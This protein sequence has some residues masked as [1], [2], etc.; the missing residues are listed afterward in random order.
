MQHHP[1]SGAL[2]QAALRCLSGLAAVEALGAPCLDALPTVLNAMCLHARALGVA[3]AGMRFLERVVARVP[4]PA[5]VTF[6]L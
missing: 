2:A 1:G 5:A 4:D 6:A 3:Y